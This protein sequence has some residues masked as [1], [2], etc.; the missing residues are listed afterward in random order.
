MPLNCGFFMGTDKLVISCSVALCTADLLRRFRMWCQL[1]D[2][3]ECSVSPG[4]AQ[5]MV[6]T[7]LTAVDPLEWFRVWCLY[8]RRPASSLPQQKGLDRKGESGVIFRR[9]GLW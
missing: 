1:P 4:M 3:S 6:S 8:G 5:D 9:W 2:C 7:S